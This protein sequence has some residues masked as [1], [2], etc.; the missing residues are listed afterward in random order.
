[1][2]NYSVGD[3][4]FVAW[5]STPTRDLVDSQIRRKTYW[6]YQLSAMWTHGNWAIEANANN[7]F[8]MN[9]RILDELNTAAYSYIQTNWT[10]QYNQYATLKVAYTFEYGK[11][12]NKSPR[13][14]HQD[15]ESAILK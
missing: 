10:R 15:S 11:R 12:T 2:V 4:S 13:Y 8:L 5:I 3:F 9:N 6:Q 1:M 14:Q 7:L